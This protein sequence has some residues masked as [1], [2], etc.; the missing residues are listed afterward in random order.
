MLQNLD[1]KFIKMCQK[2]EEF[3][4]TSFKPEKTIFLDRH[5][6]WRSHNSF[7]VFVS[8][9]LLF[10]SVFFFRVFFLSCLFSFLSFFFHVFFLNG[11]P[12]RFPNRFLNGFP[13]RFLNGS[14]H[15]WLLSFLFW[16]SYFIKLFD[17][18]LQCKFIWTFK[19]WPS[20][21]LCSF[22]TQLLCYS[23]Q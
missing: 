8:F 5:M 13:N 18:E 23:T 1:R 4:Q 2:L 11:F 14:A 16:Q 12:N 17:G 6:A 22:C 9:Y 10:I 19:T 3:E 20:T 15:Y 21:K 7:F